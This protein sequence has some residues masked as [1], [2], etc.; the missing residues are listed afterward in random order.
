[1]GELSFLV[2]LVIAHHPSLGKH[3]I[4][5]NE[6]LLQNYKVPIFANLSVSPSRLGTTCALIGAYVLTGELARHGTNVEKALEN[7]QKTIKPP[8]T[9]L[10]RLPMGNMGLLFPSSRLGV[11]MLSG[12]TKLIY[13][14]GIDKMM[15]DMDSAGGTKWTYPEYSELKFE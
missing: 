9:E 10:Q 14:L 1:M 3:L 15:P 5:D 7:Y 11:W 12:V 2:M 6:V 8:I 13:K 4:F